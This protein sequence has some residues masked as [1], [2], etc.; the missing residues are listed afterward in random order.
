MANAIK[1]DLTGAVEEGAGIAQVQ[2]DVAD[3]VRVVAYVQTR[4]AR[5]AWA[6]G[7][8]GQKGAQLVQAALQGI[9]IK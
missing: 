3:G 5:D 7:R 1:C 6:Q 8:M 4:V 2:V 9:K